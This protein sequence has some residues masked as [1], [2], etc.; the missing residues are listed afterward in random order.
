ML[1]RKRVT[2][3]SERTDRL[4]KLANKFGFKLDDLI[5]DGRIDETTATTLIELDEKGID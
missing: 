4:I 1:I 5:H 2:D 3:I